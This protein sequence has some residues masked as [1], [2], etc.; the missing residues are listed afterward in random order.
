MPASLREVVEQV[1]EVDVGHVADRD[2]VGEADAAPRRPVEDAGHDRAGLG[3][4]RE[5][6]RRGGE[7]REGGV[8]AASRHHDAQA[9]GADD[10]QQMRSRRVEHGLRSA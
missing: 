9:V 7:M 10:A 1:A 3:D 5:P 6:A 4:E 2:Q 8:Q